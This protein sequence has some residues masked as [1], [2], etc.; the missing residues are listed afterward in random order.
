[1]SV[2]PVE[3][4]DDVFEDLVVDG[5]KLLQYFPQHLQTLDVVHDF[6]DRQ[7]F[8][9]KRET[10]TKRHFHLSDQILSDETGENISEWRSSRWESGATVGQNTQPLATRG[11]KERAPVG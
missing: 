8:A 5:R 6:W 7:R 1:M 3:V 4:C 2:S 11:L 10:G 9:F